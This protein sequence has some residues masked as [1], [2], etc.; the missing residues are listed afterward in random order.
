MADFE[1]II[2]IPWTILCIIFTELKK[3]VAW[4][5]MNSKPGISNTFACLNGKT[6]IITGGNS[7]IGYT[8][9]LL[10]ASR[11]C[12][13][14]IAC[15]RN[16]V[17]ERDEIMKQTNNPNVIIKHLDLSKFASVRKF[18]E[19]IKAE[20]PKIDFLINN[21]G[22]GHV[23][24]N[25]TS[26]DGQ[27]IILQTNSF[28]HF[29]LTHLLIDLLKKSDGA[30]IVFLTSF[31]AYFNCLSFSGLKPWKKVYFGSRLLVYA[32]SKALNTMAAQEMNKKLEKFGIKVFSIDPGVVQTPIF[33]S[34]DVPG[35]EEAFFRRLF[36]ILTNIFSTDSRLAAESILH[37]I[38]S[39]TIEGGLNIF[40]CKPFHKP[41][42]CDNIGFCED[43]WNKTERIVGL[44]PEEK[45]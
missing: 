4:K 17:K 28:G 7:G 30:R 44:Q 18:A 3:I 29:L 38:S 6:A 27:D 9:S 24:Q 8:T 22:V 19:E 34:L 31:L 23:H 35:A 11:G 33:D 43:I 26:D 42:N 41:R 16:A 32:N 25:R 15:R 45:L 1:K 20:E 12:R 39:K 36:G 10:L 40:R 2:K 21:A 13:V 14:I 5:R 37:A